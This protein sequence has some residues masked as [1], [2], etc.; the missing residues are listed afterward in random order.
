[1]MLNNSLND[2][3]AKEALKNFQKRN[4]NW[5]QSKIAQA[6]SVSPAALSQWLLGKYNGDSE[7]LGKKVGKFLQLRFA[8]ETAFLNFEYLKTHQSRQ[9]LAV[10]TYARVHRSL[11]KIIGGA[12]LGKTTTLRHFRDSNESVFLVTAKT[13]YG[14]Y[15]ILEDI[16]TEITEKDWDEY[17]EHKG[18]QGG[19]KKME[20]LLHK[21]LAGTDAMILVDEA[22]KLRYQGLEACRELSDECNVP[23]VFCGSEELLNQTSGKYASR[24]QQIRSRELMRCVLKNEVEAMDINMMLESIKTTAQKDVV[25]FLK[26]KAEGEGHYRTMAA[27][28]RTA[29]N[30][31]QQEG[32]D[33]T[34]DDL[35]AAERTLM[36][37]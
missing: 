3:T 20:R 1:M 16:F 27:I 36:V 26:K 28:L 24:Y 13:G 21:M 17:K 14:K 30:M 23:C 19:K 18:I 8:Q 11:G 34:L 4:K 9:A 5:S 33:L 22:H 15:D 37:A 12:G 10:L 29:I 7:T 25:A 35:V 2:N 6:M 32:R 31:V